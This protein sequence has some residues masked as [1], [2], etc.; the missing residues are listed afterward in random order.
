VLI[1]Y[2]L[3]AMR[4]AAAVYHRPE[5]WIVQAQAPSGRAW[6]G[7]EPVLHLLNSASPADIGKAV[8][9]ALSQPKKDVP[10]P[11]DWKE[12]SKQ[13]LRRLGMQTNKQLHTACKHCFVTYDGET[14]SLLLTEN[15]K[16]GF[17]HLPD[18]AITTTESKPAAVGTAVLQALAMST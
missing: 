13:N 3:L 6:F 8:V 1:T 12:V 11:T 17:N 10:W 9:V 2:I 5:G 4:R 18:A 7:D 15:A 14:L 16:I